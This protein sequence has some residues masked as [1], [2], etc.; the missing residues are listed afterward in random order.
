[1]SEL[2]TGIEK[3]PTGIKGLDEVMKGGFPKGRATLIKG[4][5][6]AG[7]TVFLNSF[8]YLGI[9]RY[10]ENGV[11][12]TFE[13]TPD[14]I[15]KNVVSF[16]WNYAELVEKGQ[17]A[18]VDVSPTDVIIETSSNYDFTPLFRRIEH[19]IRKVNAKRVA[20]DCIDAFFTRFTNKDAVRSTLNQIATYLKEM[21][22]TTFI[23]GE[24]TSDVGKQTRYGV[25]EYVSDAVLELDLIKG[26]QQYIRTIFVRKIRGTDYIN[27][28]MEFDITE[29]G[30][31]VYPKIPIRKRDATTDFSIRKKLGIPLV[32]KLMDGGIPQGHMVLLSGNTGTGKTMFAMHFL[33]SG[34]KDGD[35]AV[36]VAL[37][38]P[39]EQLMKTAAGHGWD[40]ESY[41]KAGRLE[42]VSTDLIDIRND[43]LLY[44]ILNAVNRTNAKRVVI[45]S[46][47]SL[48]SATMKEED[49]RQFLIQLSG[50]MKE[51]GITCI[52]NYLSGSS[53]G[54]VRGQ[55]LSNI[56]TND[57]RLSSLTDGIILLLYVERGQSVKKMLNI[58]KMR[59]SKHSK[60]VF[61]YEIGKGR[62]SIIEKY[63][64]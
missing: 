24:Q 45:D 31:E 54:A 46:V 51:K 38:E 37:E 56:M 35:N 63:E 4:P 60:E 42:F 22:V 7:K 55:L 17:L 48:M 44:E 10:Q 26:Q 16:G 23:S 59:G 25:E 53:F 43:R 15:A 13:E 21:G 32:D 29:H 52:M 39:V 11:Y 34:L 62:I 30:L 5:T 50:Y 28:L 6:G 1:M 61:R 64:E 18:F 20:I 19:A 12:V 27:G 8:I 47:S 40:L 41:R 2:R 57:M 33:L 14:D 58:L 36:F 3:I 9:T 49:V